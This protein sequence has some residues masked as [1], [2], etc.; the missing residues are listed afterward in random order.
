M[1]FFD[2]VLFSNEGRGEM[3]RLNYHKS[4]LFHHRVQARNERQ[5]TQKTLVHSLQS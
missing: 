5:S 2:N 1:V 4:P 3:S